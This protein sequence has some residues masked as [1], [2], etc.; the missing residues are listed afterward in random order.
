MKELGHPILGDIK[1]GN[2]K[3]FSRLALHAYHLEFVH[4]ITKKNISIVS[5]MPECFLSYL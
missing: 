4:P 2:K 1:Y 5:E 3:T